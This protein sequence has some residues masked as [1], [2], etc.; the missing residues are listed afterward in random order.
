LDHLSF[1]QRCGADVDELEQS[2]GHQAFDAIGTTGD[3]D[4]QVSLILDLHY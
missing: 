4:L 3:L 1:V 2:G